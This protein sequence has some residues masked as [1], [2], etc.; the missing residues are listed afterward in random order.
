MRAGR[1]ISALRPRPGA[2]GGIG[3]PG[4]CPGQTGLSTVASR[5]QRPET[6]DVPR[7]TQH[8]GRHLLSLPGK[9]PALGLLKVR[10]SDPP[11]PFLRISAQI[12]AAL[13]RSSASIPQASGEETRRLR[14]HTDA[15]VWVQME[16]ARH[17]NGIIIIKS[18]RSKNHMTYEK[19]ANRS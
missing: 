9:P 5:Q 12:Q 1:D 14:T 15:N 17:P 4:A 7:H 11:P 2:D 16:A 13:D 10:R 3:L 8:V 6:A 19:H 18:K